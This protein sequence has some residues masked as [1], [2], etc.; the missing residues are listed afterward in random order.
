MFARAAPEALPDSTHFRIL[1]RWYLNVS[2]PVER[3]SMKKVFLAGAIAAA[4]VAMPASAQW[5]VGG[6]VGS[7]KVTGADGTA[8]TI[9]PLTLTGADSSKASIKVYG[10]YQFT[11][12]WGVEAQY[13]DLG[14]RDF[15][16]RNGAGALL[17]TGSLKASQFSV[18]GTG[19]LPLSN[20][21]SL[22]GKLGISS[23]HGKISA[24]GV[25]DSG[26]KTSPLIGVGV[27][28]NFSPKL[29]VRFE[30]EDFGKFSNDGGASGGS[31]RADNFGLSLQ[32]AF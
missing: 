6:G 8:P 4:F 18:A 9:P 29:A 30:Y 31:I 20:N 28:Y 7:S 14:S 19:T 1:T 2:F 13:A 22:F 10:G 15:G 32:Y 12:N 25:S 26:S 24:V 5:Y 21:F 23:N 3:N 17:A 16:I 27:T 11:P